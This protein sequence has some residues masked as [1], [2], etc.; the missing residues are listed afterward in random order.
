MKAKLT[1]IIDGNSE[2]AW[3]TAEQPSVLVNKWANHPVHSALS[4]PLQWQAEYLLTPVGRGESFSFRGCKVLLIVILLI[5]RVFTLLCTLGS[6]YIN[7]IF[8]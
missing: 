6:L 4:S 7:V 5:L 2:A 8:W 3:G 1:N